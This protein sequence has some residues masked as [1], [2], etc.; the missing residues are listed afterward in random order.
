MHF[1]KTAVLGVSALALSISATAQNNGQQPDEQTPPAFA[2]ETLFNIYQ[3]AV[4]NDP[5]IKAAEA[6]LRS[7]QEIAEGSK[8]LLLPQIGAQISTSNTEE[9]LAALGSSVSAA[10]YNRKGWQVTA[11]QA[12]FDLGAWYQFKG[13]S[14]LSSKARTNFA[15]S[16]QG[17]IAR[18]IEAYFQV[19]RAYEN[20]ESSLAEEAAI[21]QQLDQTQQR[22]DVGLVAIT[23]VHESQAAYD[24]AKVARLTN[25]G[26]L[27]ISYEA[28]GILTGNSHYQIA[29]VSEELPIIAP[30]PSDR[31]SWVNMAKEGNLQLMAARDATQ[32]SEYAYRSAKAEHYPT[33]SAGISKSDYDL[34]DVTGLEGT[35]ESETVGITLNIPIF[36]GGA[37]SANRRKAAADYDVAKE[38]LNGLERTIVQQTRAQHIALMTN[39]QQVAARKQS[40]VSAQSALEATE[41]GYNVGTRNIVDVLNVQRNLYN[42]ERNYANARFDYVQSRVELKKA[43]GLLSPADIDTI[44]RW[45]EDKPATL[46]E[47]LRSLDSN[48]KP[49]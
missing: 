36:T 38:S 34:E 27:S 28:L 29:K 30:T 46:N 25:E 6:T 37:I 1:F 44:N 14:K 11:T 20:L 4:E 3:A 7:E 19:L 17:L 16:Q 40:I 47:A 32:A 23:D 21:K 35:Q 8:A 45:L 13:G 22:F 18:T 26:A 31:D 5:V 49:E 48:Y 2:S 9:K 33:L 10:D 41:A 12:L 42:A 39:I 24:L 15:E 43:A